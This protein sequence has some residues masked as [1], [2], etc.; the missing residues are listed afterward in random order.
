MGSG[1][2]YRCR[3]N[4]HFARECPNSEG[5]GGNGGGRNNSMF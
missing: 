4:G 3:E 2:C 1:E 5:D